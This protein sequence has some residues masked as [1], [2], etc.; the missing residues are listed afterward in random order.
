MM[1]KSVIVVALAAAMMGSGAPL[2]GAQENGLVIQNNGVDSSN[3]A[4]GA[5]NLNISRAAGNSSSTNGPGANNEAG[6]VVSEK[7][8]DRKDRGARNGGGG[9]A[10]PAEAAPAEGDYQ[11]YTDPGEWVEPMAVP[12]EIVAESAA[13]ALDPNLP[14]QL[15]NTGIGEPA[16]PFSALA[17]GLAA[18][19]A[20][21]SRGQRKLV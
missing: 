13:D 8:R 3:S 5:D 10:A 2:A 15:P 20:M 21:A 12:Q 1:R 4:A 6:R 9:E 18:A 11:E 7:N 14:I 17:A 19:F 16:F